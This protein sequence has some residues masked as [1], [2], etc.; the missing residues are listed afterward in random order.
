MIGMWVVLAMLLPAGLGALAADKP[1]S[2][3]KAV[4]VG[5]Q[6]AQHRL[7]LEFD[8]KVQFKLFTLANPPRLVIDVPGA[9]W[10]KGVA[11]P[12]RWIGIVKKVRHGKYRAGEL[13]IVADLVEPMGRYRPFAI[14]AGAANPNYRLV[15]DMVPA[16]LYG[17]SSGGEVVVEPPVIAPEVQR[18]EDI[19]PIELIPSEAMQEEDVGLSPLTEIERSA[20]PSPTAKPSEKIEN[21]A[22]M[23]AQPV[24]KPSAEKHPPAVPLT[25]QAVPTQKAVPPVQSPDFPAPVRKPGTAYKP[26][27]V[28]DPGHGGIDPGAISRNGTREKDVTLRYARELKRALEYTGRYRVHLTRGDD[29]YLRLR[30][31]IAIAHKVKG[32][33]FISLHADSA[34]NRKARGLSVYT[35]SEDASDEEAAM[36]AQRENKVDI[37]SGMDLSDQSEE[38]TGILI[39]LAQRETLNKSSVL[40]DFVIKELAEKVAM[41]R[42]THRYA[43]FAVLKAPDIPSILLEMGFL[44]NH[45]DEK[46]IASRQYRDTLVASIVKAIDQF[47]QSY[48]YE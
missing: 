47:V 26:L 14:A 39:D 42:N 44:S 31:R 5:V 38:V 12:G 28:I 22:G 15:V 41:A 35:L 2:T 19:K 9:R 40:A 36:L 7:V 43:G 1:L 8:R 23:V 37:L 30:E 4:R 24:T 27:I 20:F 45:Q 3:V 48:P 16:S 11:M 17:D 25:M 33:L 21:E 18:E 6:D 10:G 46:L 32:D 34:P 29:R 13:R